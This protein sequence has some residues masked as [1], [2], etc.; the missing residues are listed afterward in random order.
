MSLSAA[1]GTLEEVLLNI[2]QNREPGTA[3]SISGGVLAIRACDS[4]GNG[5]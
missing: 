1:L 3:C 5:S 2:L 4:A